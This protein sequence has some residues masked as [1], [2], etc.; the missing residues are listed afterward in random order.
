MMLTDCRSDDLLGSSQSAQNQD[1][2]NLLM[3]TFLYAISGF[4]VA[5]VFAW[6]C[7]LVWAFTALEP[8]DSYWD[9]TP[10]TA[11][12]FVAC[13]LLFGIVTAF[14][15][16]MWSRRPNRSECFEKKVVT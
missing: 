7:L 8:G 11:D 5:S 3:K 9:R 14:G 13:S 16:V 2:S 15:A 6:G 12:A 1:F 10:I 4:I